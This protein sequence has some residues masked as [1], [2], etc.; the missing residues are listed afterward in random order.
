[1]DN[2]M[3]K[4]LRIDERLIHGQV[5]VA[6]CTTLGVDSVIVANDETVKDEISV[7]SLKMAAPQNLKV[8]IKSVNDAVT[9]LSD[10]RIESRKVLLL[11]T[12]PKDALVL[13]KNAPGIP[14]VNVGNFGMFSN[15]KNRIILSTSF[16]VN[17]DERETF[18]QIIELRPNSFYQMTPTLTPI[19]IKELI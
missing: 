15:E 11:V 2:E 13:I 9:L 18:K 17:A 6:W 3:I 5:A 14:D 4:A 10:P 16:A 1:M 8:V 7:M 19:K 12:N